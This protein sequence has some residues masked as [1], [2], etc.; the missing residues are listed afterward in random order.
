MAGMIKPDEAA[1]RKNQTISLM[2][3]GVTEHEVEF[4]NST[5][6]EDFQVVVYTIPEIPQ[7]SEI[8]LVAWQV[9]DTPRNSKFI[10][11]GSVQIGVRYF[12]RG[13]E[14]KVGPYEALLGSTWRVSQRDKEDAVTLSDIGMLELSTPLEIHVIGWWRELEARRNFYRISI[15]SAFLTHNIIPWLFSTESPIAH[16]KSNYIVVKNESGLS[17]WKGQ[18]FDVLIYKNDLLFVKESQVG[19]RCQ[20]MVKLTPKLFFAVAGG[21]LKSGDTFQEDELTTISSELV[22][23]SDYPDGVVVTL[24]KDLQSGSYSFTATPKYNS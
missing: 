20:V 22:D 9:I 3:N 5:G 24:T 15:S 11:P 10:Y 14:K 6:E 13:V 17:N 1:M 12:E 4:I 8:S 16:N 21:G 7:S 18:Y 19:A 23:L 2:P